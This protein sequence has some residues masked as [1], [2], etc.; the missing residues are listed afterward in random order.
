MLKEIRQGILFTVVTMA[1][2]GGAYH[3]VLWGVGR[4]LFPAQAEGSLIRRADGVVVGSGLIAQ[5]F[6]RPE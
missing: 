5:K 1:L 3:L 2:F 6:S 4:A